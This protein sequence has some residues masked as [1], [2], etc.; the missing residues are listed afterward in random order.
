MRKRRLYLAAYDVRSPKRLRQ[1]LLVLKDYA[2]GGQKSVFECYLCPAEKQA[3]IRRIES[4]LDLE[5]DRFLVVPL[6]AGAVRV[7]GTAVMPI[8][9]EF[10]YLG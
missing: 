1:A 2:S 5:V 10:F 8:D 6:D 9:A 4:V 3:L 7:L